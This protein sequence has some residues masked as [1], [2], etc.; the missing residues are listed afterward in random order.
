MRDKLKRPDLPKVVRI[1]G[2]YLPEAED[3]AE[4][5]IIQ[6]YATLDYMDVLAAGVASQG[7]EAATQ[8][9]GAEQALAGIDEKLKRALDLI[10]QR[11]R[12]LRQ[13]R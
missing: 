8:L 11:R 10:K 1:L 4:H 12:Q 3:I 6:L 7:P 13:V 2:F 5:G 9:D